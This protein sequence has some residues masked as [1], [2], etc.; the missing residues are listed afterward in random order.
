MNDK[1]VNTKGKILRLKANR[2]SDRAITLIALIVTI[3]VLLVL[4]G[5][6]IAN[7][8]GNQG[9]IKKAKIAANNYDTQSAN[10]E[11]ELFLMGLGNDVT[12]DRLADYLKN[13]IGNDGLEDFQN[14]GDGTG[15]LVLNGKKYTLHFNDLTFTYDGKGTGIVRNLKQVLNNNNEDVPGVAMVGAG[16]IETEDLGWEVLSTNSDGTVNLI[17][18]NNTNFEV[19]L[20][21]ING[22]TNGV[23]A[24]NDI[25]NK[26]YGNL[27]IN[28][29]KV[30]SARS[31]NADDFY[32][33]TYST[34]KTY[35][36]ASKVQPNIAKLDT[37]NNGFSKDQIT[38]Y[39]DPSNTSGSQSSNTQMLNS[40][41]TGV[42]IVR[43][44]RKNKQ[45]AQYMYT[46]NQYWIATREMETGYDSNAWKDKGG[47]TDDHR[48][49]VYRLEY[50]RTDGTLSTIDLFVIYYTN[51]SGNNQ[52][53]TC[54]LR[55]VITVSGDL[56][57][58]KSIG[59]KVSTDPFYKGK[60]GT[61]AH[62][63]V[64]AD[65]LSSLLGV[66]IKGISKIDAGLPVPESD[67]TWTKLPDGGYN[68]VD[69]SAGSFETSKTS[70]YDYYIADRTTKLQVRL[71]GAQG[72][73]NGVLA[74]DTICNDIYGGETSIKLSNGKT[75]NVKVKQA[76]NAKFED[77]WD[78]SKIKKSRT[79]GYGATYSTD[80]SKASSMASSSTG[81]VMT[82]KY[83][84]WTPSI[85]R[86]ESL[87]ANNPSLGYSD[88]K[89]KSYNLSN[90]TAYYDNSNASLTDENMNSY[91][92]E[93]RYPDITVMY[94]ALWG[95]EA[96][97]NTAVSTKT[98]NS[99]NYWLSSHCVYAYWD[100]AY[101][102]LRYVSG[103][104]SLNPGRVFSSDTGVRSASC[105]L[106]PVLVVE[107]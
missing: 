54:A 52:S 5:V 24:L 77:F 34:T 96:N 60:T 81:S 32:D 62:G 107:K 75:K 31:V 103:D 50:T 106:R 2:K 90:N 1:K 66:D 105:G 104:G 26:L 97:R 51:T 43:P 8:T 14:N 65:S 25:C 100:G 13:Y 35:S 7:V 3:V 85:Y 58:D 69:S 42:K 84:R 37:E 48:Y 27:E 70:K 72:Y 18:I 82:Y 15:Q 41:A 83:N 95:T 79:E 6:T 17:A 99:Q 64:R 68:S 46:G 39:I 91:S 87:D 36:S 21:G 28:G 45:T 20:S 38:N 10:E 49:E 56:I 74:L 89:I 80:E 23:K 57:K 55:P 88:S 86:L 76:R 67:M 47:D 22:Y 19:S 94:N 40:P 102:G 92:A 59:A 11:M 78:E 53:Q 44:T 12:G 101:F 98:S 73:N 63:Y 16:D 30:L 61:E 9:V 29:K 71:T 93:Y 33:I 4:A